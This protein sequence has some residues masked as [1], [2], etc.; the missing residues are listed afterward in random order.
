[1]RSMLIQHYGFRAEDITMML[2]TDASTTKPTGK[3]I[4][5]RPLVD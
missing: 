3:N 5:A 4:K 1:M 2:D